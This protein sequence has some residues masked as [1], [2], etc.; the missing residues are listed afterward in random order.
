MALCLQLMLDFARGTPHVLPLAAVTRKENSTRHFADKKKRE[1]TVWIGLRIGTSFEA[2]KWR[3][4][5]ARN[6]DEK[7]D[8]ELVWRT[9]TQ[10][11][12][13]EK[14]EGTRVTAAQSMLKL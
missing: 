6:F 12:G 4:N 13:S 5:F 14:L 7:E 10:L 11:L 3:A 1:P 8:S 2:R 9:Y